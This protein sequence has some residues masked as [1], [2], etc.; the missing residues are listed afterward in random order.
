[1]FKTPDGAG[2]YGYIT[3]NFRRDKGTIN[4]SMQ[5]Q[6]ECTGGRAWNYQ[7]KFRVP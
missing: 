6:L 2:A 3:V 4:V 7:Q 5:I 1:L